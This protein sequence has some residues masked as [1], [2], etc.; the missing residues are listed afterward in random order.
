[1]PD[2]LRIG[3]GLILVIAANIALGSIGAV[4]G[5]SFDKATFWKG[6]A[7]GGIVALSVLAVYVAGSLNPG[8]LVID[9]GGGQVNLRDAVNLV[10]LAAYVSYGAD[11][12]GK[13]KD[14]LLGGKGNEIHS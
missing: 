14:A 3:A 4:L 12:I 9:A 7:K 2:I 6:M 10:M 1:M 11:V 5:Q 8:L 13:L